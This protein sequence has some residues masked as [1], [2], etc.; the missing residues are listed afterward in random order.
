M[1]IKR[2]RTSRSCAHLE[3]ED[4][5]ANVQIRQAEQSSSTVRAR[6][7]AARTSMSEDEVVNPPNQLREVAFTVESLPPS[8]Q[9]QPPPLQTQLTDG[10]VFSLHINPRL[11]PALLDV[12][13]FC[14]R[15]IGPE[16]DR[17]MNGGLEAYCSPACRAK[18]NNLMIAAGKRSPDAEPSMNRLQWNKKK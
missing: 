13:N 15:R 1:P 11:P 5:G 14:K 4:T 17:Y 3:N 10:G 6:N 8:P 9:R 2:S 18:F 7:K 12:C 16:E